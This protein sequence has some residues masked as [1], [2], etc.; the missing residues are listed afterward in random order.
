MTC[1]PL[2]LV[3]MWDLAVDD[4][5]FVPT[6]T[7]GQWEYGVPAGASQAVWSTRLER[8]TLH[9]SVERLDVALPSTTGFQRPILVLSHAVD[10]GPGDTARLWLDTGAGPVPLDVVGGPAGGVFTG[11]M[12][13][14]ES[15]IELPPLPQG[16]V[17]RFELQTDGAG[18]GPGWTIYRLALYDGDPIPPR[19]ERV[20]SP[21]DTQD[22]LGP[23]RIEV[24]IVEDVALLDVSV[25]V[26][27]GAGVQVFPM[28]EQG[29][30]HVVDLPAFPPDTTVSWS[31]EARDCNTGS[32]LQ[33]EPFR[34]YLAAPT[35]LVGPTDPRAV[36]TQATLAWSA[37]VSPWP[38]EYYR[39]EAVD[40]GEQHTSSDTAVIVPLRSGPPQRFRVRARFHTPFGSVFGDPSEVLA[41]QVEVPE[42]LALEPGA[43]F[44]GER[45]YVEVTGRSFY[46]LEGVSSLGLV[47][48][49]EVVE[50]DVRDVDRARALVA[51]PDDAPPG[52]RDLRVLGPRG[53]FDFS[54]VFQVNDARDAPRVVAVE[55]PSLVQGAEAEVRFVASVPYGGPIRMVVDDDLI[56]ASDPV[57]EGEDLWVRLVAIGGARPGPHTVVIDDGRRLLSATLEV[58]PYVV[59][60]RG[61]GV[62]GGS[63][64]WARWMFLGMGGQFRR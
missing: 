39:V 27:D 51:I 54:G 53:V 36:G 26:D 13:S 14:M 6:G 1:A 9:D 59:P 60:V 32:V 16:G 44:P 18:A 15:G 45:L 25:R 64:G 4:G 41:L 43:G 30:T 20:A 46:L 24:S 38:V 42:L 61:C 3:A 33:G 52:P 58:D 22:L 49:L 5:G 34:V 56:V 17:L 37:P 57:A 11:A 55:P 48:D 63:D 28:V 10:L 47:P 62:A 19:I 29:G 40:T 35:D 7:L 8:D 23:H 12:G 21:T 50:L 31:V 2:V